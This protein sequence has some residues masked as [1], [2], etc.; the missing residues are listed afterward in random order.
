VTFR[1][2]DV[3]DFTSIPEKAMEGEVIRD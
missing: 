2:P 1:A 3:I